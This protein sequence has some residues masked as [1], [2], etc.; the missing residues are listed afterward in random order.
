VLLNRMIVPGEDE[1]SVLAAIRALVDDLDSPAEFSLHL[2]PPYY[3]P[4]ETSPEHP[5]AVVVA[6]ACVEE[7]SHGPEWGDARFGGMNLSSVEAGIPRVMLG[8]R[9]ARF[10]EADEWVDVPSIGATA[11][12]LVRV[13]SDLLPAE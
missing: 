4:W 7:R 12:L 8:P 11:H 9:G 10:H 6:R 1:D 3:P 5:L 2:D 13:A